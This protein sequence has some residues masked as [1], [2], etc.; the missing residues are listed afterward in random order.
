[1]DLE[2]RHPRQMRGQRLKQQPLLVPGQRIR[3]TRI[4]NGQVFENI[5][6]QKPADFSAGLVL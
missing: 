6:K 2:E 4:R 1:V 3:C 5:R